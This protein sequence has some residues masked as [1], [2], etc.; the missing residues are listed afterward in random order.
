MAHDVT[1]ELLNAAKN[2][3]D[4]TYTDTE[5]DQKLRGILSRGMRYIEKRAGTTLDFET[6][7]NDERALLFDYAMYV[8]SGALSEFE[9]N[10]LHEL[11]ALRLM[12]IG[13]AGESDGTEEAADI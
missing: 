12:S 2:Y 1:E 5:V 13:K 3:L 9:R 6:E 4:I 10:Y 11:T 8:R 7:G